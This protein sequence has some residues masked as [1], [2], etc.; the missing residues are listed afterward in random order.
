[1]MWFHHD[2]T[3]PSWGFG[4]T[5]AVVVAETFEQARAASSLIRVDYESSEA[6]SSLATQMDSAPV[7]RGP[8]A[9]W[10]GNGGGAVRSAP[11]S[12][13]WARVRLDRQGVVTVET[14]MTD[15]GTGSYTIVQQTAAEILISVPLWQSK[16][17]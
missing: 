12:K 7:A 1:M 9:D 17:T 6:S 2:A 8:L 4:T 5:V 13:S 3:I 11:I 15:I 16:G 14:D 10:N